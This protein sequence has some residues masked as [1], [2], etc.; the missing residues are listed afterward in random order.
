[1]I[2]HESGEPRAVAPAAR[3]KHSGVSLHIERL[4]IEGVPLGPGQASRMQ[5]AV[6]REL[7]RLIAA[8]GLS[9]GIIT[10]GALPFIGVGGIQLSSALNAQ[11]L[12]G[13]IAQAVYSGL[14][15]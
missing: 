1:M 15:V 6:E 9:P 10:V 5:A 12:G 3:E 7:A 2:D 13:Q 14:A 8:N 4:V 11:R